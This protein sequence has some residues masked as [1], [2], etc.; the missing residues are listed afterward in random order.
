MRTGR[1]RSVKKGRGERDL[2]VAGAFRACL[3]TGMRY[4]FCPLRSERRLVQFRPRLVGAAQAAAA[5]RALRR[6]YSGKPKGRGQPG[7]E[8]FLGSLSENAFSLRAD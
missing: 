5:D 2:L 1:C 8:K 6:S 4:R 7:V 3:R